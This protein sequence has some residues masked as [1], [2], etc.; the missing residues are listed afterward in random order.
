MVMQARL[1]QQYEEVVLPQLREEL[2][3]T[4]DLSLPKLTK[5]VVSMGVG[6]AAQQDRK[7]VEDA[8]AHLATITGQKPE[9]TKARKSVAGFKLREGMEVGCRV[10]LRGARMY[11]FLD[12]LISIVL[13]RVRDFRGLPSKG[14]DKAGNYNF[15]LNEQLVFPEI[16]PDK[17]RFLQGM[18]I[19]I[20]TT[21]TDD[22]EAKLLLEKF[23]FPFTKPAA[24]K[25][26]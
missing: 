20:V 17:V 4:N 1:R 18:N 24:A 26:K 21:T 6:K 14:F 23:N 2:G 8:A 5:I 10:T 11:E 16:D 25:K 3:R 19:T 7:A 9:I 12:R 22:S 15:G 13:P